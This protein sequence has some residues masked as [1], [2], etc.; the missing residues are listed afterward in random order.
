MTKKSKWEVRG[1]QPDTDRE[2]EIKEQSKGG[3]RKGNGE[4]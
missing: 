2:K 1:R 4:K 3:K